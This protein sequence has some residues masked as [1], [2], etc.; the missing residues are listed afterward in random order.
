V[1]FQL[2]DIFL[3]NQCQEI[4]PYGFNLEKYYEDYSWQELLQTISCICE[5]KSKESEQKFT[6]AL[7]V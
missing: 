7:F 2:L 1:N 4:Y 3:M 5:A 6:I